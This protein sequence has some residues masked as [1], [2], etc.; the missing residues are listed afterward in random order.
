MTKQEAELVLAELAN[1]GL[2]YSNASISGTG[3]LTVTLDLP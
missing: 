1:L 2:K 3:Q